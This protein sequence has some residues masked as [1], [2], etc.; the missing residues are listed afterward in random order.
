MKKIIAFLLAATCFSFI[1]SCDKS[2]TYADKLKK[3]SRAINRIKSDSSL[4]FLDTYPE[5]GVFEANE[6]Y[7]DPKSGVYFNVIDSGNGN[8]AVKNKTTVDV[9]YKWGYFIVDMDTSIHWRNTDAPSDLISFTYNNS[10]PTSYL[11]TSSSNGYSNYYIKSYGMASVL[12]YVGEGAIVKL[13]VPFSCGSYYQ[14]Y[15]GYEPVYIGWVWYQ[16]R[17]S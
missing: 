7:R 1:I 8:R 10:S 2:E 17:K 5:D 14:Q 3:E 15:I 12:D 13:I 16:F 4:V 6:F 11:E 9:R